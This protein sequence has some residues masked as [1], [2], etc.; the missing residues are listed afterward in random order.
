M[1]GCL[2]KKICLVLSFLLLSAGL[3]NFETV[4]ES[5]FP[6]TVFPAAEAHVMQGRSV[7]Q[8]EMLYSKDAKDCISQLK[9]NSGSESSSRSVAEKIIQSEGL[10][11]PAVLTGFGR[12][13][14]E[15]TIPFCL[16]ISGYLHKKDGRK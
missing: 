2:K 14:A 5:F 1:L 3:F 8:P 12:R 7:L 11:F 9:N 16:I 13:Y 10:S 15:E 6:D 4:K